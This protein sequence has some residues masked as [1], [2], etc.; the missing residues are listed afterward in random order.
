[1]FD[2]PGDDEIYDL[3]YSLGLVEHFDDVRPVVRAHASRLAPG[4]VVVLGCP[5]FLGVNGVLKRWLQP[6]S[7]AVHNVEVMRERSWEGVGDDLG[8]RCVYRGY[9]GGFE[10]SMFAWT[11][12]RGIVARGAAFMFRVLGVA[13]NLR[14]LAWLRKKNSALFSGYFMIAFVRD[15]AA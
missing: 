13:A 3:V 5:S 2:D 12:R 9:V 15:D 10:P 14:G 7:Y 8:L 6:A 1:M 11:E 4:G